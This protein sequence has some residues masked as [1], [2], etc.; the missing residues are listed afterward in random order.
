ME[1]ISHANGRRLWTFSV[2]ARRWTV[3]PSLILLGGLSACASPSDPSDG[4][5]EVVLN[6]ARDYDSWAQSGYADP[7]PD[8]LREAVSKDK[9]SALED[10][11]NWYLPGGVVQHGE[12]RVV[13]TELIP[14]DSD[15]AVVNVT[16]D[17]SAVS[18]TAQGQE[19]WVDNSEPI[20]TQF[21][22]E[23]GDT[24]RIVSTESDG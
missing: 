18:I 15:H 22:L 2:R 5:S 21:T 7:I 24:W 14:I 20:V 10:D 8:S 16:F 12:V 6:F 9:F 4:P 3:V 1:S 17:A 13:D 11:Q 23:K 19:T